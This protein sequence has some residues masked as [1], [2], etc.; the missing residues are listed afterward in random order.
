MAL[1]DELHARNLLT[2]KDSKGTDEPAAIGP[3]EQIRPFSRLAVLGFCFA[4][5]LKNSEFRLRVGIVVPLVNSL[6][7][8][9]RLLI[10]V[11]GSEPAR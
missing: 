10:P 1:T 8:G 5:I 11:F 7:G 6:Q 4:C 2:A 3:M 9:Q